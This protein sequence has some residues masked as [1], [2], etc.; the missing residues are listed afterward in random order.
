MAG[1]HSPFYWLW[2]YYEIYSSWHIAFDH[3]YDG[4]STPEAIYKVLGEWGKIG[5][6][7]ALTVEKGPNI[8][9]GAK[10]LTGFNTLKSKSF[11]IDYF[12]PFYMRCQA[13]TLQFIEAGFGSNSKSVITNDET[14][15]KLVSLINKIMS[16]Y[17][18]N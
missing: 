7:V 11:S 8:I 14:S 13:H 1:N 17:F 12:I 15:F 4:E 16:F 6:V 2:Y 5:K 18:E 3:P 9:K 10:V